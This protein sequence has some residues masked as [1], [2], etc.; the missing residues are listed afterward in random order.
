MFPS[1]SLS[2][3]AELTL[4]DL[5]LEEE[6]VAAAG[7]R[8]G[9]GLASMLRRASGIASGIA[10]TTLGFDGGGISGAGGSVGGGAPSPP[11]ASAAEVSLFYLPLHFTRILLTI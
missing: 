8:R 7:G 11:S 4:Q 1:S 5:V 10:A 9:S 2:D 3:G 6:K